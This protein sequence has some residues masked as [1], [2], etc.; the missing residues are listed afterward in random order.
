M[1]I[2]TQEVNTVNSTVETGKYRPSAKRMALGLGSVVALVMSFVGLSAS[3]AMADQIKGVDTSLKLNSGVAKA[4]AANGVAVSPVKPAK[5]KKG[6]VVFPVTG[7]KINPKTA[8]S[9][10]RH[11]G[12]LRFKAG[13]TSL[14][15]SSFVV[16]TGKSNRLSAKVGDS[17][18]NL[19]NLNLGKAKVKQNG[20]K[21][22]V[23]RVGVSLTGVAA[24]AL[25]QTFGVHLFQ[26]NMRIGRVGVDVRTKSQ[27][28]K[29]KTVQLQEK[30]S[31]DL[32]LDPGTAQ[33]LTDLG[34][35]AAPIGPA[36]VTPDGEIAFP[37]T[38]GKVNAST[39]AGTIRHSGG[40]SLT[41]GDTVVE[42]TRFRINIDN[43][44]D[45]TALVGG[46]RVSILSL[47]LSDLKAKAKG[48]RI[49]LSNVSA[50][51]TADA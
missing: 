3:Q 23:G 36:S 14:V 41:A 37:I 48:K 50:S 46:Q 40:L 51:L 45:L 15:A 47:D 42:L 35:A 9:T 29:S 25:N 12:G 21:I 24:D 43:D 38:G 5:V 49:T 17:R 16:K 31:T 7:G 1:S 2:T 26:K 8:A 39:Y 32:A 22:R 28:A 34:V 19:L 13:K 10:I 18:V 44:P 27:P 20:N 11:S 30:G 33:A 6:A 4:L